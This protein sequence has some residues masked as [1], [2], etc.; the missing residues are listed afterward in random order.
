MSDINSKVK[1]S[2]KWSFADQL[3]SQVVFTAFGIYLARL[4]GPDA[5]GTVG[6]ITVFTNF[7]VLFVDM[8]FGAALVQQKNVDQGHFS[9][10]FW[11]NFFIGIFLYLLFLL[12]TP[13]LS[14]FYDEPKLKQIIPVISLSF[15]IY[16]FSSVQSNILVKNL[17]FKKK[18]IFSWVAKLLGYGTAFGLTFSGYDGV[19]AIVAMSLVVAFVNTTLYWI[20]SKWRPS[21]IFSMQKLKDISKFG[22]NYTGDTAINYWS[23]NY[24]N[25][26]I[27]KVLGNTELGLYTR[28]YSLMT[29]PLKNITSV[30]SRVL[31]PAFSLYQDD[32]EKIKTQYLK[33]IKNI[34]LFTFPMLIG[35]ALVSEEFVL[36][37]FGREWAK[38]IPIIML[39]CLAGTLQSLVSLNGLIY[40]SLART[41]IAFKVTLVVNVVL[42]LTFSL[43]VKYGIYYLALSYTIASLIIS[44]PIY[45]I[46][47]N[48]IKTSFFEVI[49]TIKTIL[50]SVFV[51]G[52]SL[53]FINEYTT[54]MNLLFKLILKVLFG[55][56]IY[57]LCIFTFDKNLINQFL[58]LVNNK[59]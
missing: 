58:N 47:L 32:I 29:L 18:V 26:I 44:I 1:K 42:I 6:M 34:A 9:T 28:A 8:G 23:R 35:L 38:M 37:F 10:V 3:I 21:F 49:S 25:F 2:L 24:D 41:D 36:L 20:S 5:Y 16:S 45:Q 12:L 46:A 30:F 55:G 59:K 40:N 14:S 48:L 7:A 22:L 17:D 33:V 39:L 31:F 51:M 52:V 27:G 11:L 53:F 54:D 57:V 13:R 15:I 4:L 19:W 43:S 50:L 56:I